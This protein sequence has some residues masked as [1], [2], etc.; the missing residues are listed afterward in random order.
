MAKQNETKQKMYSLFTVV[1][2]MALLIL[3]TL[4]WGILSAA[5]RFAPGIM[6]TLDYDLGEN[7]N[8]ASFPEEYNPATYP[9]EVESYYN[10]REPFRSVIISANTDFTTAMENIYKESIRPTLISLFYSEE[11]NSTGDT[12][13]VENDLANMFGDN[14]SNNG[15]DASWDTLGENAS[16]SSGPGTAASEDSEKATDPVHEYVET[17]HADA[18]CTLAGHITYTCKKCQDSYTESLPATGHAYQIIQVVEPDYDNYGYSICA[19]GYCNLEMKTNY[20]QKLIDTTYFPPNIINQ[21][22]V[23]GRRNWLFYAG[24]NSPAYYRGQLLLDGDTLADYANR[25]A[26]L[27]ALCDE[28]G[29]QLQLM[30]LPN[31]EQVYSEYMPSYTINDT[32]KRIPRLVDY[33]REN[34]GIEILYPIDELQA[35]KLYWQTYYKYDTHWTYAGAFI[36]LQCLYQA[37]GLPTTSLDDFAYDLTYRSGGDL[38]LLAALNPDNYPGDPVY[39]PIYKQE[40]TILETTGL[41]DGEGTF[42]AKTDSTNQ[43]NFVLIGD[44]Y[45][46]QLLPFLERDFTNVTLTHRNNISSEEIKAAVLEADILVLEAVERYDTRLMDNVNTLIEILSGTETTN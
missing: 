43:C 15:N 39:T 36:G 16:D 6:D 10:D 22:A 19:C 26:T 46:L 2:F 8:K 44:S 13:L 7:R 32:Y 37:L 24:N 9:A 18:T 23:E 38:V 45:R 14:S 31:K 3:P 21:Q 5:D 12:I 41:R 29:I 25:V 20:T 11:E 28:K 33:V 40:V 27:Q 1:V 4:A 17:E 34:T 42:T 30:I 35:G